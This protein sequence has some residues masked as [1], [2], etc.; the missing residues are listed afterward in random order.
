MWGCGNPKG[1]GDGAK[2]TTSDQIQ[3]DLRQW[4]NQ[5]SGGGGTWYSLLHLLVLQTEIW[6]P[7]RSQQSK[8]TVGKLS[9]WDIWDAQRHMFTACHML[10]LLYRHF[11]SIISSQQILPNKKCWNSDKHMQVN[12][13]EMD[14]IPQYIFGTDWNAITIFYKILYGCLCLDNIQYS[15]VK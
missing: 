13:L 10:C 2:N 3:W 12:T 15:L 4:D 14:M 9:V 1:E 7:K 8:L 5:C 11:I 6:Y